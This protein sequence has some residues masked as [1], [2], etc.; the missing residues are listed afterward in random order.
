MIFR[1]IAGDSSVD[2]S[3]ISDEF[4]TTDFQNIFH[5]LDPRFLFHKKTVF[6]FC[7]QMDKFGEKYRIRP[8]QWKTSW[9]EV[10]TTRQIH[11]YMQT[12]PCLNFWRRQFRLST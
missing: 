1:E 9:L 6:L 5:K 4:I 2:Q 3:R 7:K 8:M 10:L 11:T 12:S